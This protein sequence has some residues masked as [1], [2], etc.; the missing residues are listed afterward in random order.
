MF[1]R[2]TATVTISAPAAPIA[3]P[4]SAKDAYLPVPTI[5]RERYSRPASRKGSFMSSA[6]D[7]M[8]DL[9]PV[10]LA[11]RGRTVLGARHDRPVHLD[12]DATRPEPEGGPEVGDR[13][14]RIE[15]AGI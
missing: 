2:R 13:G 12:R 11:E 1:T 14:L 6:S 15:G 9:D 10:A 4:V 3:R 8:D 5:S 7:K